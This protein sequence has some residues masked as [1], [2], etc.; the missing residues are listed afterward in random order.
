MDI[1]DYK[2]FQS[3]L[4]EALKEEM[5]QF[6]ENLKIN[7]EKC[8]VY[9]GIRYIKG[10]KEDITK[11][12]FES[13][14]QKGL[15]TIDYNDIGSYSCSCFENVDELIAAF[16]LPR[17]NKRIAKGVIDENNGPIL[18]DSEDSHIH[19]FLYIGANPEKDFE[20]YDNE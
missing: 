8:T 9:R 19:W 6:P 1:I 15:T 4:N 2:K 3:P 10:E 18:K 16:H 7:Y 14:A 5:V 13:H 11:E 20:V 17:K 12:D